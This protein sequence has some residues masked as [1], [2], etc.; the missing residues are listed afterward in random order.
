[1]KVVRKREEGKRESTHEREK[2]RA[3]EGED[4]ESIATYITGVTIA[5]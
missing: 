3:R 2:H 5:V 1:M 4:C